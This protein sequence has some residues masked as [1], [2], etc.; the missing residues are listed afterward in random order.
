MDVSIT[1]VGPVGT[2]GGLACVVVLG[3]S[4]RSAGG[5]AGAGGGV[6]CAERVAASA[7]VKRVLRRII[8]GRAPPS[9]Y[10]SDELEAMRQGL[11]IL[12]LW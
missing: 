2:A 7:I 11:R 9:G 10:R 8:V 1:A 5:V 4:G 12:R 3:A 6:L